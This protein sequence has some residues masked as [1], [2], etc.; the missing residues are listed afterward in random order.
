MW[1]LA[2]LLGACAVG[3]DAPAVSAG[4]LDQVRHPDLTESS[5][6]AAS[7]TIEGRWFTHDDRGSPAELFSFGPDGAVEVHALRGGGATDWEDL[8]SG[9]CPG[10][11]APCLFIADT[12]DNDGVRETVQIWVVPE[13]TGPGPATVLATW[14]LRY[15]GGPVDVEALFP[16]P[17]TDRWLLVSKHKSGKAQVFRVP[18]QPGEGLVEVVGPLDLSWLPKGGRKITAG[19]RSRDGR[20]LSLLTPTSVLTWTSDPCAPEAHWA[21][22]PKVRPISGLEQPEALAYGP[23]DA[24][25][26]SSEGQPMP[27]V[28]LDPVVLGP[29]QACPDLRGNP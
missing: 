18:A 14:T 21:Q 6:L 2:L 13:P 24:L 25:W 8:H 20:Q 17:G 5:G 12:G 15:P 28:R 1:H 19:A 26:V 10:S 7:A 11:D 23:D 9:R 27:L 29:A 3:A 4:P 22:R 16:E